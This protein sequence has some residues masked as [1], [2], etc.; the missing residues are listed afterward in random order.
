MSASGRCCRK[1]PERSSRRKAEGCGGS[2]ISRITGH[3]QSP[4]QAPGFLFVRCLDVADSVAVVDCDFRQNRI[5][6]AGSIASARYMN[7]TIAVLLLKNLRPEQ[8]RRFLPSLISAPQNYRETA[9]RRL[10][11]LVQEDL[12]VYDPIELAKRGLN[13]K[14]RSLA[15]AC[16]APGVRRT[17][18]AFSS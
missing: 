2:L 17:P 16:R 18:K 10:L 4:G 6:L 8:P 15:C 13:W 14:T 3:P 9:F 5:T 7:A 12:N 1:S 11:F